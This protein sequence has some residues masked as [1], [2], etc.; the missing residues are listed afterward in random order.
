M[1]ANLDAQSDELLAL[2]SIYDEEEFNRTESRQSGK[3]HL[4]LELPPNFRLLVKGEACVEC[5]ISFLPP[6][7]LSFELPTDYPS[8][9]A[10]VFTL[11]SKW[12]SRVQITALCKRLD[13]LWEE[14]RGNV[15]LFTWIQFLKEETLE[16]L[17]IQSPLEIRTIGGQPQYESGQ[18]QAVDT[19]VEKSKVQELDQ[20]AVQEFDPHTDI[21]TQLLDFNDA[22]KQKVF[23]GKF[24]CCGICFA[25]NLGS[26][27]L[28]FKECQHVYC[29]ACVKEYFQIQIRD[30]KVQSLTCPEPECMSMASPAQVKLLVG[31]EEFARYDHLLLRSSLNL[32]A[33][34]DYCPHMSCC[35]AV[36]IEPDTKMGMCPSCQFVF[37]TLCKRTYHALALCKECKIT[38][39]CP[40]IHTTSTIRSS[41]FHFL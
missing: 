17:N 32:M 13:K 25:E 41:Q 28:L 20:R 23:D 37:C 8:S 10:P 18:N 2:A 4:C 19:A 22:Q 26:N 1:S 39:E 16:F 24:F 30:G 31:E 27:S 34:V 7:V 38:V 21:L 36:V 33:D 6:L 15:I 14:N 5:G 12:L 9:S 11:S 3:I 35:M 40:F 29:K